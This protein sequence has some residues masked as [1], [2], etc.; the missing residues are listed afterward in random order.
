MKRV[1]VNQ[2]TYETDLDL[3]VGDV[4]ELPPGRSEEN[5]V[6]T[7]TA[8]QSHYDG[9]CKQVIRKLTLEEIAARKL[10]EEQRKEQL[11]EFIASQSVALAITPRVVLCRGTAHMVAE[12]RLRDDE[13]VIHTMHCG[14]QQIAVR[15]ATG[16]PTCRRC[17]EEYERCTA[18]RSAA[19]AADQGSEGSSS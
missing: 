14:H 5:W 13:A 3:Q 18:A 12:M 17:Y 1:M 16:L 7:V 15:D 10:A 8:L 9:P 19:D 6:G 4:V 11:A 2:W